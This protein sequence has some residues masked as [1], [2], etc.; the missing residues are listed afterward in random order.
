MG[1]AISSPYYL[2][3]GQFF[4]NGSN[5]VT[6]D[7]TNLSTAFVN[8]VA[9]HATP[10][11]GYDWTKP[12][13]GSALSGHTVNLTIAH[14]MHISA[15]V[16][17][18]STTVLS[19]LTFGTPASIMA[20]SSQP[21]AMDQSWYVCRHVFISTDPAVKQKVDGGAGTSLLPAACQTDLKTSLTR[22]WG[23]LDAT[24]MCGALGFDSIPASCVDSFGFSRQDVMCMYLL[25]S[26][27]THIL[28][29]STAFDSTF[30]ANTTVASAQVSSLQQPYSWRI[31]TQYH[32]PGSAKAYEMAA[33][34]TYLVATVW[35]Y[36]STA[37]SS[38][39]KTPEVSFGILSSGAAYVPP[40]PVP[41]T[42][43]SASS[44]STASSTVSKSTASTTSSSKPTTTT[45]AALPTSTDG[46]CGANGATCKGSTFGNCCSVKGNCGSTP[47]FCG[48]SNLCQPGFGTCTPLSTDG[49]CG[50]ASSTGA[51]CLGSTFGNCCSVKGNC[52]STPAFCGTTNLCQ[53]GFGTCTPVSTDGKCGSAST[54]GA[55]CLGS[56]F[57]DCCSVKGNCGTTAAFCST[58]NLCQPSFG[59]CTA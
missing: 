46:K 11:T 24:Y 51:M 50:S 49:K 38:I 54:V 41:N 27:L 59:T 20:D 6:G 22:D 19:S 30:L 26:L 44:T 17:E 57:G 23:T 42:T 10:I 43:T 45:P 40:P 16:V 47:A 37:S 28:I 31:G 7:W 29:L 32:E 25:L 21:K 1:A 2:T 58:A 34:R 12:F 18:D 36:S 56:S 35:G 9:T 8:P 55:M 39:R 3:D 33:N 15:D 14:E 53:P 13:P 4:M 5:I 52:G 48:V